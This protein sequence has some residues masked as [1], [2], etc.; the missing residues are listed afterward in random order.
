MRGH[1]GR[2]DAARLFQE[3]I[4]AQVKVVT[5]YVA[6]LGAALGATGKDKENFLIEATIRLNLAKRFE[7]DLARVYEECM[8]LGAEPP[9]DTTR[10]R[11]L[12]AGA[13]GVGWE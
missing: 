13:R 7:H 8:R 5:E 4:T 3:L 9:L 1:P 11:F 10:A 6:L 12:Y 2:G